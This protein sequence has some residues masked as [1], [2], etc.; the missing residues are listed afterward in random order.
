MEPRTT[1]LNAGERTATPARRSTQRS[2]D[3][4]VDFSLQKPEAASVALAGTFN[5]WDPKRTPLRKNDDG[6]WMT[7][8]KLA[9]GRYEYRFVVDGASWLSDPQTDQSVPNQFGSTNSVRVV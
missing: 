9:P 8:L 4:P 6:T 5:G 7:T 2:T 1:R 3:K